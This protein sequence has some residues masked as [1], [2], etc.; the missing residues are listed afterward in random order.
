MAGVFAYYFIPANVATVGIKSCRYARECHICTC[1][2]LRV[3]ELTVANLKNCING[4]TQRKLNSQ[5]CYRWIKLEDEWHAHAILAMDGMIAVYSVIKT[6]H[7]GWQCNY[8]FL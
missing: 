7:T 1:I 5:I 3:F 4:M 8:L 2:W 6:F